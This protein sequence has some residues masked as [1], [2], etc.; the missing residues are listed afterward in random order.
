[1]EIEILLDM[2]EAGPENMPVIEKRFQQWY[3]EGAE[4][5]YDKLCFGQITP[6]EPP[7]HYR[8]DLGQVDCI[9]AIQDLHAR[10][11]RF[12]VKVFVHFLQ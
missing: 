11:Y 3:A 7:H 6:L 4:V 2:E 5:R 10:L 8:V 9:T 1:M 12:G